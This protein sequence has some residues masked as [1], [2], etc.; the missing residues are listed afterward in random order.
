MTLEDAWYSSDI[1][2]WDG[3]TPYRFIIDVSPTTI[4][5]VTLDL[6]IMEICFD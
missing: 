4:Y 6:F 2:I 1:I 5:T 3:L